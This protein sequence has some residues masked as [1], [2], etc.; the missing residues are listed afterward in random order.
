MTSLS[1][2][3]EVLKSSG[4]VALMPFLTAGYPDQKTFERLLLGVIE[5][6]A[7]IV[8][9]GLPFSDPLADGPTIQYSSHQA[10]ENGTTLSGTLTVLE[11]LSPKLHAPLVI[12]SYFNPIRE[13]G[14]DRFLRAA[15]LSKVRGLIVPD[16]IIE[17]SPGL[18]KSAKES[19]IDLIHLLAPTSGDLR[20][21][22]IV[23]RSRGFVYLVSVAGVTGSRK[24]LPS[25]LG[26]W[27]SSVRKLTDKPLCVGF[28]ISS[29]SLAAQVA[30]FADGVI[31]GSAIIDIIRQANSSSRAIT[32]VCRFI[33]RIR[34]AIDDTKG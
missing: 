11:R 2:T 28:G 10:L 32:E 20:A 8:E 19:K 33:T 31:I 12:M 30:R 22:A 26:R 21:R 23:K 29:P 15:Y 27:T 18:E 16:M 13:Y 7:D 14:V 25:T 24:D 6:G 34:K 4:R 17:E 9:V 1:Q 3:F 5:A